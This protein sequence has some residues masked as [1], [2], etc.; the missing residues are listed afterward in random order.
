MPWGLLKLRALQDRGV[1]PRAPATF[2]HYR[3]F[4]I[5]NKF[6]PSVQLPDALRVIDAKYFYGHVHHF[7]LGAGR[8][9]YEGRI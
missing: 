9:Q 2:V 7:A 3:A 1:R 4:F 8:R 6:S 5:G